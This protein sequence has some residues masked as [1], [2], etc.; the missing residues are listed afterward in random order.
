MLTRQAWVREE[1]GDGAMEEKDWEWKTPAAAKG[2]VDLDKHLLLMEGD[3]LGL[4][5]LG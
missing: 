5:W 2:G 4:N 3:R 1:K